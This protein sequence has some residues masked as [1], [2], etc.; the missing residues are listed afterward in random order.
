MVEQ[1]GA[2]HTIEQFEKDDLVTISISRED[3]SATDNRRLPCLILNVPHHDC[4]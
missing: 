4:F 2:H 1:Y 3:C